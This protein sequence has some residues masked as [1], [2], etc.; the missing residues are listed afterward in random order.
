MSFSFEYPYILILFIENLHMMCGRVGQSNTIVL[1]FC[2]TKYTYGDKGKCNR[3]LG[4]DFN[5]N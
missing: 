2:K 3:N 5:A 1:F 4:A